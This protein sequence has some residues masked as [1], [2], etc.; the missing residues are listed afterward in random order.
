MIEAYSFGRIVVDGKIYIND[1]KIFKNKVKPEW[2][3]LEGHKLQLS[4]MEDVIAAKPK[5]I[6]VGRGHDGVM[7]VAEEVREFCKENKIELIELYTAEAVKK[8]NEIA[9]PGVIGLFHLTC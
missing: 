6:V 1:I 2:W 4:D 5:I 3:R 7:V 9:G 8:F